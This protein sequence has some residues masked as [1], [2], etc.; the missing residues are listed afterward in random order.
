[1]ERFNLEDGSRVRSYYTG[2]KTDKFEASTPT[3]K[4]EELYRKIMKIYLDSTSN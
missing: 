4:K 2:F 3:E 1:M